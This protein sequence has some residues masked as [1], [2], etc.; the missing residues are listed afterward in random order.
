MRPR[1]VFLFVFVLASAAI[2]QHSS[3]SD[4]QR[5]PPA[6]RVVDLKAPDGTVLKGT[7]FACGKPGPGVILFHQ[8]NRTRTSWD[9]IARHL[10]AAGINT[11]TI[12]NRGHGESG[13]TREYAKQKWQA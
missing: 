3:K 11:L 12:D 7:Y 5:H 6:P 2:A 13:G 9:G 4:S 8:N 1:T 10:A